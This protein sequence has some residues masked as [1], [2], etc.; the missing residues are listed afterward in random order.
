MIDIIIDEERLGE[1]MF[2][3]HIGVWHWTYVWD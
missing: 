2:G 3:T 1:M